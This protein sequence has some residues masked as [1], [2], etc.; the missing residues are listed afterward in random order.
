MLQYIDCQST[1]LTKNAKHMEKFQQHLN[2]KS[3]VKPW[4]VFITKSKKG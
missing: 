4:D 3:Y 1:E 2:Y